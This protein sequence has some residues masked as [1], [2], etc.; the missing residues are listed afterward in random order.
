MAISDQSDRTTTTPGTA[1]PDVWPLLALD[2]EP[3]QC[4]CLGCGDPLPCGCQPNQTNPTTSQ[5]S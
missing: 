2:I 1:E 3:E 4:F 5:R